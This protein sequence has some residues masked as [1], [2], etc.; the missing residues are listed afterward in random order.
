MS[1]FE[2]AFSQDGVPTQEQQEKKLVSYIRER[3]EEA[4][5]AS[6]RISHEGN[7]LTNVA[8]LLGYPVFYDTTTRTFRSLDRGQQNLKRN[9]IYVNKILPRVQNRLARL[10]KNRPKYQV[11]PESNDT[12]DKEAAKLGEHIVDMIWHRQEMNQKVL[13][14]FMWA[15]QAGHSYL[16]VSWD[17]MLGKPMHN[18]GSETVEYEGDIRVDVISAFEVFPDPMAKTL[19]DARWIIHAKVRKLDYFRE[20]YPEKGDQVKAEGAWL[21]SVQYENRINSLNVKGTPQGGV[22][23]V[24]KNSA[25]E[26]TYYEA[27]SKKYPNG[28]MIVTASGVLL[29]DK[30]LPVGEIPFVKFDDVLVAGKYYS[31]SIITHARP[32]QDQYNR[33]VVKRSDWVNKLVA[34]KY[35]AARG[36]ELIAESITDQSGEVVLHTPVPNAP[37][38]AQ[39]SIPVMPSYVYTEEERLEVMM[40]DVF[41]IN[42]VS[43]GRA[44]GQGVTAAIALSYLSEQDDTRI[45]VMSRRHELG[46][47]KLGQLLLKYVEKFYRNERIIKIAGS[48]KEYMVKSFIGADLKGNTDVRVIEGSTLP[49]SITAK[50]DLILTFFQQGLFGDPADPKVREKVLKITEFGDIQGMWEDAAIDMNKIQR[51]IDTIVEQN[52]MPEVHEMDNHEMYLIEINKYRKQDKYEKLPIEQQQMLM[53]LMEMHLDAIVK[54]DNPEMA[55][56]EAGVPDPEEAAAMEVPPEQLAAAIEESGAMGLPGVEDLADQQVAQRD[57]LLRTEG[58]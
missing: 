12:E 27:R 3:V 8:Y 29:E 37:P 19:R 31:E 13:E 7:W 25:I 56:E 51:D 52:E 21:L 33:L 41:G 28:R 5:S 44:P 30:E 24:L 54:R 34:G 48:N 43:Q 15:Q 39:M 9:R 46:M 18:P 40:D 4:R 36:H 2:K 38:P 49:G 45:G 32:I 42:E 50:R 58:I 17:P 1:L 55:A 22:Q 26:L 53:E 35:L 47:A 10:T 23:Q 57:E 16:K 6:T 20:Q 14:L 11:V